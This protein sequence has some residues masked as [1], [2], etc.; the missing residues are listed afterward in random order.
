M[1]KLLLFNL[2]AGLGIVLTGWALLPHYRTALWGEKKG[3]AEL[4]VANRLEESKEK[5]FA[6]STSLEK[7]LAVLEM[8][9]EAPSPTLRD[10]WHTEAASCQS[11][12]KFSAQPQ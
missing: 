7:L 9:L 4:P 11:A 1:A 2:R 10:W 5:P 3:K 12:T 6:Y 8:Q